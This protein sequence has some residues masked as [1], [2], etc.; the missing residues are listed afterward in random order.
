MFCSATR[1]E[2]E[3]DPAI[4]KPFSLRYCVR[5]GIPSRLEQ[6]WVLYGFRGWPYHRSHAMR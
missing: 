2:T 6:T 1:F 5:E 4:S 3:I